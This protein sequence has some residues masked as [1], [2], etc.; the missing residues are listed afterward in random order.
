MI[1]ITAIGN[2]IKLIT[3]GSSNMIF[4][5]LV[6]KEAKLIADLEL[7]LNKHY[8]S[9]RNNKIISKKC[10]KKIFTS[11]KEIDGIPTVLI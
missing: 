3:L 9:N 6:K 7:H 8:F 4:G 10:F 11:I 1:S 5:L 2:L